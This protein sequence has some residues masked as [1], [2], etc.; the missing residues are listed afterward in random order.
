MMVPGHPLG[1]AMPEGMLL[2]HAQTVDM[3]LTE[4]LRSVS[5]GPSPQSLGSVGTRL[6]GALPNE[7]G[8]KGGA[9]HGTV[10]PARP[11]RC[12]GWGLQG[13]RGSSLKVETRGL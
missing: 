1:D 7:R 3:P 13:S 9:Y 6:G 8:D 10:D 2:F 5:R 11:D 12:L 4:G